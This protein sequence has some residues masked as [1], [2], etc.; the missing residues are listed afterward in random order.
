VSNISEK[1]GASACDQRPA[2]AAPSVPGGPGLAG[3]AF[4]LV[5]PVGR[6]AKGVGETVASG[7]GELY[8]PAL[9]G[10]PDPVQVEAGSA[11]KSATNRFNAAP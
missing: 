1:N 6:H 9:I 3:T 5:I 8:R 7:V 11:P 2:D 4:G 10:A